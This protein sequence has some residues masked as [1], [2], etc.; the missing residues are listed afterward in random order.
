M[1][2][3]LLRNEREREMQI[4]QLVII[5]ITKEMAFDFLYISS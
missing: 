1:H 3:F 5:D 2:N 4:F